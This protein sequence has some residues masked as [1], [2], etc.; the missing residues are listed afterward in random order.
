MRMRTIMP[1]ILITLALAASALWTAPAAVA[2]MPFDG[3]WSVLIVTDAGTCDRA[4]RYALNIA[5]GRVSYDDPSFNVSGHVDARGRVSVTVSAG[6]QRATG[7]GELSG[8]YGH[9]LWSGQSSVSAC[10]GHWEAERR[11]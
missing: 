2:R 4:Y 7:T 11:G 3:R 6:G 8:D 1:A 5:N 9:G 10:S